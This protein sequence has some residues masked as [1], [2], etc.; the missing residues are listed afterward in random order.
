MLALTGVVF[1]IYKW[2]IFASL[3]SKGYGQ[4]YKEVSKIREVFSA[5]YSCPGNL[6]ILFYIR[7]PHPDQNY[8]EINSSFVLQGLLFCWYFIDFQVGGKLLFC[9]LFMG[10]HIAAFFLFY[11]ENSLILYSRVFSGIPRAQSVLSHVASALHSTLSCWWLFLSH[12][13]S[14]LVHLTMLPNHST[15]LPCVFQVMSQ[16]CTHSS[17]L[18]PAL[19]QCPG[20]LYFSTIISLLSPTHFISFIGGGGVVV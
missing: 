14:I 17:L 4:V 10:I 15:T 2:H 9:S 1:S 11:L 3:S 5:Y 8:C 18:A 12:W 16:S 19:V 13:L 6:N 20:H 7:F